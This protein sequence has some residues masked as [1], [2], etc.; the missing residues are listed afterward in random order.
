MKTIKDLIKEKQKGINESVESGLS[1]IDSQ[2]ISVSIALDTFFENKLRKTLVR[3]KYGTFTIYGMNEDFVC[4]LREFYIVC[5]NPFVK[6][7][8]AKTG[9]KKE[10]NRKELEI[11]TDE[12]AKYP[13][14]IYEF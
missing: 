12:M 3:G 4:K 13:E 8:M 2:V 7:V 5:K 11:I 1:L 10:L 6:K 9:L 14:F